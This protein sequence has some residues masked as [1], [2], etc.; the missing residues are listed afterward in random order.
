MLCVL[1]HLSAGLPPGPR[2]LLVLYGRHGHDAGCGIW[3]G[4][5]TLK[6]EL[7]SSHDTI[8]AWRDE[9]QAC[10]LIERLPRKGK[11]GAD[12]LRLGRCDDCP[13]RASMQARCRA[14]QRAGLQ[15]AET[16]WWA[17]QRTW[18]QAQKGLRGHSG[19]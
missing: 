3:L 18:M 1:D 7:C 10:R 9:L 4:M 5:R 8:R 2:S 6:V 15:H 16:E 14:C 12:L 11:H 19:T 17:A 13:Q